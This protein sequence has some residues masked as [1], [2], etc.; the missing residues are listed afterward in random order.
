[1]ISLV[2]L[3]FSYSLDQNLTLT[4]LQFRMGSWQGLHLE[5]LVHSNFRQGSNILRSTSKNLEHSNFQSSNRIQ[6]DRM[7]WVTLVLVMLVF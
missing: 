5:N 2:G 6:K 3:V 7:L 4:Y 1:M